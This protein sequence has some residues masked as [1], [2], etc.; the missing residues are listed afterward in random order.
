MTFIAEYF[1]INKSDTDNIEDFNRRVAQFGRVLRS[2]RRGRVFES[3]HADSL[4]GAPECLIY[5]RSGSFFI[6][7]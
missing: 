5:K 4:A 7:K 2:G 3:R 6:W 1:T